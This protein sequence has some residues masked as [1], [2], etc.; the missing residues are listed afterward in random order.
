MFRSQP[1]CSLAAPARLRSVLIGLVAVGLVVDLSAMAQDAARSDSPSSPAADGGTFAPEPG[2]TSLFDGRSLAGW[3]GKG[4]WFRVED[5]AIVAGTLDKPIPHNQFLCTTRDYGDFELRLQVKTRGAGVNGGIQFRSR[6]VAPGD[7]V[8]GYQADIG[9]VPDRLV[10]GGL[11]DESR[12]NR[13]LAEADGERLATIIKPDEWND[14]VIRCVGP[15]VELF[16]NGARTIEYTESEAA[17]PRT[18]LIGVQVHSGPPCEVWY[19]H[20][21]IKTL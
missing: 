5:Q 13:F 20:L 3:E 11:Y 8:S 6:R 19:R 17:I 9:G 4:E 16:I 15:K 18:G 1:H 21:R 12:R 10:W 2:F 7:E 14:Y